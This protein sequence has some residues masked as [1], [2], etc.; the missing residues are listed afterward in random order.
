MIQSALIVA[1]PWVD[2]L[3]SGEKRIEIRSIRTK[4]REVI[5]LIA[6]GTKLIV[7]VARVVDCEGPLSVAELT[8]LHP[9]HLVPQS[10]LPPNGAGHGGW[11]THGS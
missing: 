7:G 4:K 5:G 9:A 8:D 1:R 11:P 6:K 10:S 2:L 3:L